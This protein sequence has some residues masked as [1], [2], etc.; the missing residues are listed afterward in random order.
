MICR[1]RIWE[2]LKQAKAE[3]MNYSFFFLQGGGSG[4]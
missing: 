1:N 2:E 4:I 3:K